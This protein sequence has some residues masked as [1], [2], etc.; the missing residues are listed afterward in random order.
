MQEQAKEI[1]L[2]TVF[3]IDS[4]EPTGTC[5]LLVNGKNRS[6]VSHLAASYN[7]SVRYL[8]ENWS[9]IKQLKI[10]YI[11]GYFI[12]VSPETVQRIRSFALENNKILAL[13]L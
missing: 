1:G 2:K 11:V 4:K 10:I 8:N 12:T 13:N 6:L 9:Y 5:I 7:F 3:Q